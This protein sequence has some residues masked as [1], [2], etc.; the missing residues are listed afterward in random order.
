MSIWHKIKKKAKKVGKKAKKATRKAYHKAE[1]AEK[2]AIKVKN[3]AI[4][5]VDRVVDP[6]AK[7][8]A[9]AIP[10]S[11]KKRF[12][13]AGDMTAHGLDSFKGKVK[14]AAKKAGL[15]EAYRYAEHFDPTGDI[16]SL[17][18]VVRGKKSL[19]SAVFGDVT[20]YSDNLFKD[21]MNFEKWQAKKLGKV[22]HSLTH[23]GRITNAHDSRER[24][25]IPE[26]NLTVPHD[27]ARHPGPNPVLRGYKNGNASRPRIGIPERNLR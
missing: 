5:Q 18:D 7:G 14:R 21:K 22:A 13:K 3:K 6:I 23:S 2:A 8:A 9:S 25:K 4:K 20:G 19:A 27:G 26:Q 11:L 1:K 15:S 12:S 16:H 17:A 10:K 24:V